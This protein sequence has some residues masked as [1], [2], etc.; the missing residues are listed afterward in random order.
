M[1]ETNNKTDRIRALNDAFRRYPW[2]GLRGQM[3]MTR[4]IADL[5][6]DERMSILNRVREFDDFT[7]DN[8]PHGEH[9]CGAFDHQG[10]KVFWKI[11]YYDPAMRYGSEDPSD[12][13]KTARV[14]TI[15]LASEY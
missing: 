7:E 5:T 13:D 10:R 11:D 6:A 3:V 1:E 9:D 12:P 15:M 8:D 14:L 4:G 2:A